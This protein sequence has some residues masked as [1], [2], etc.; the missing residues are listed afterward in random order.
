VQS[1]VPLAGVAAGVLGTLLGVQPA[2]MVLVGVH[3]VACLSILA[4]D[5]GRGRDLPVASDDLL[6]LR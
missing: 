5:F 3:A 2:I 6:G 1:T 4:T